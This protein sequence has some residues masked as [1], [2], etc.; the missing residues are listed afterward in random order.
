MASLRS[1]RSSSSG[2]VGSS[3]P[4]SAV[5]GCVFARAWMLWK[6]GNCLPDYTRGFRPELPVQVPRRSA[7]PRIPGPAAGRTEGPVM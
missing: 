5:S 3:S 6:T 1:S 2:W 7:A 4:R